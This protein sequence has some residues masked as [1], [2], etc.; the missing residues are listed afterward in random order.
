MVKCGTHLLLSLAEFCFIYDLRY[1]SVS[2]VC[3]IFT[4]FEW[5]LARDLRLCDE[6]WSVTL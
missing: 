2:R 1:M 5:A 6:T 3:L 4:L